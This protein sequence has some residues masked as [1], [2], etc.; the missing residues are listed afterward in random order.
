[1]NQR[2][3]GIEHID[4]NN[5]N[6]I[7]PDILYATSARLVAD[8]CQFYGIPIDRKHI[9]KHSEVSDAPTGCPDA[10]DIE[11]IVRQAILV[12]VP[13]PQPPGP[14]LPPVAPDYKQFSQLVL[15]IVNGHAFAWD[16]V[17]GIKK[18][19]LQMGIK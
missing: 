19:A 18:L 1:M 11:R 7:R 14:P 5:Y 16:K 17:N 9:L 15:Q 4:D 8:I 13:T 12:P 2:S 10:L 3:I 6:G